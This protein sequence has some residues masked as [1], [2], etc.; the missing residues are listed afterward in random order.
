MADAEIK[1][2]EIIMVA[3]AFTYARLVLLPFAVAGIATR[4]GWL[5]FLAMLLIWLTDL[6]DGKI[7]RR[8]GR[9]G[10]FG[11]TL[12]STVDFVMIY[13]LFIAYY[14]VG[15][16]GTHQ[17]A[18]LYLAMLSILTL[19][20]YLGAQGAGGPIVPTNLGKLTGALQY[21]YLLYLVFTGVAREGRVLYG[22]HTILF[23]ALTVVT[24]AFAVECGL[25]MAKPESAQM[26][27][28]EED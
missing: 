2:V 12:D 26:A 17:F 28:E 4:H 24:L 7:A 15:R 9:P 21:I 27:T 1:R 22:I 19:Q 13:S 16:L 20:L 18:V 11:K 23:L 25:R 10:P 3:N 6:I 8:Q 5:T 14:A